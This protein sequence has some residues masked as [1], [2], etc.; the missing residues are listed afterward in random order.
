ME[1]TRE[2][3]YD[4]V[5]KL[6]LT[7]TRYHDG[8]TAMVIATQLKMQRTN[9]SAALNAL[10]REHKL[11]KT[12]TRP[13]QFLLATSG[14]QEPFTGL[15]GSL[16]SLQHAI[17]LAKAA[18]LYPSGPLNI[19]IAA[20]D[21]AGST[22]FVHEIRD[23]ARQQG[24]LTAADSTTVVNC[25]NYAD[26]IHQLDSQLFGEHGE[27]ANSL[28]WQCQGGIVV[29]DHY[30][31]LDG[32]QRAQLM[33]VMETVAT[34]KQ[35]PLI[36]LVSGVEQQVLGTQQLIMKIELPDFK[37]RPWSER[38][39]LIRHFLTIEAQQSKRTIRVELDVA[40]ALMLANYDQNL[41]TLKATITMACAQAYVRFITDTDRE[42][43]VYFADLSPVVQQAL[44]QER[45]YQKE[46]AAVLETADLS[47][48]TNTTSNLNLGSLKVGRQQAESNTSA[49]QSLSVIDQDVGKQLESNTHNLAQIVAPIIIEIVRDWQPDCERL[50]GRPLTESVFNGLCLHINGIYQQMPM[51]KSA[52]LTTAAQLQSQYAVEYEAAVKLT[53]VLATKL[54]LSIPTAEVSLL[55]TF[56]VAQS[57]VT[58]QHPVVLYVMHGMGTASALMRTTNTLS[59]INNTYAYDVDLAADSV[60]VMKALKHKISEI[61]GGAGVIIIYDMGAIKWMLTTIQGELSTK[62]RMIQIPVTLVGLDAARKSARATDIDDVYHLVKVDLQQLNAKKMTKD[63][64]IITLCHT[65]EGGAAQLKDYIDKYSRLQM[66]VKALAIG[67]RDELVATVLRLQ[68]VYQIHAFVG[69]FDPQLFGIPFISMATVFE[70][71]HQQLD[72]VLMFRP[73]AGHWDTYN[74]IYQYFKTQFEYAEVAKLQ[75]VLPPL[76]DDLTT[77]YQLTEDQQIGLFVHLGSMIERILAGKTETTTPPTRKL[78]TQYSDDYQQLR[79]C[80]RPIEQTFKLIV[81]DEMIGTLLVILRQLR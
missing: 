66:R 34:F 78:I 21:G 61:D 76:M 10:V 40:R 13:V 17:K 5:R 38:W 72:Q 27:F 19:L 44:T 39:A 8:V 30:D 70:H 26:D 31:Y 16:N 63:E 81:N 53:Q 79:R 58:R 36:I 48:E 55:V 11:V 29:I 43:R 52:S 65:G 69:T 45:D 23:F 22:A 46:L 68:Q 4:M 75:R 50:L 35:P 42:V 32:P 3:I 49:D 57:P 73:E 14:S 18:V 77:L 28:W 9:V 67:H 51:T 2:L 15:I 56:L 80:L 71:S 54:N 37:R 60:M 33:T 7:D 20:N 6:V 64:L 12:K 74:Q 47:F 24:M 59:M 41:K 25:R 1:T 62:I